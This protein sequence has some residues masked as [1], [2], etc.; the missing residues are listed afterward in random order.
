MVLI[1]AALGWIVGTAL[2]A[3]THELPRSDRLF[4]RPRCPHCQGV[5]GLASLTL[6]PGGR[7]GRCAGCGAVVIAASRSLELATAVMFGLLYWRFDLSPALLVY[8]VYAVVLLVVLAIDLQHRWVYSVICYPAILAGLV[9]TPV[10]TDNL[11]DGVLGA[12]LGAGI[13]LG[14]Y[15]LGRLVYR[16]RE[17]MGSGDITIAAMIGAMVGPQQVLVA[18]FLGALVVAAV[19]AVLLATRRARG[20]DFIPYGAGLCIGALLVLL[21]GGGTWVS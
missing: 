16:G 17:P 7:K 6:L 14:L 9:L 12:L 20:G 1:W 4:A 5:L 8:S 18:L 21:R 3:V 2:N 15:W 19:S 13:F 10:V 11:L